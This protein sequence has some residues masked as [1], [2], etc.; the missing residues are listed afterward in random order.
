GDALNRKLLREKIFSDQQKRRVLER[1]THPL[2]QWRA[3]REFEVFNKMG[4]ELIFYDAA[5]IFE[6]NMMG[7][8]D[9]FLVVHIDKE[10]QVERLMARDKIERAQAEKII[11]A[12]LPLEKKI[13]AANF[14]IDNTGTLQETRQ[15]VI[16]VV[17]K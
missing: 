14:L 5:L 13:S 10:T 9:Q 17:K 3:Q 6:K 11:E 8:F 2:I 1:I 7:L 12:Q 15:K 4:R 16:E